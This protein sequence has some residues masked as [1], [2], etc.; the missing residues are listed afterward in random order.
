MDN[1]IYLSI[2]IEK[3]QTH[4]KAWNEGPNPLHMPL[5]IKMMKVIWSIVVKSCGHSFADSVYRDALLAML[6]LFMSIWK[7]LK[8]FSGRNIIFLMDFMMVSVWIL[9]PPSMFK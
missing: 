8:N 7:R 3:N 6:V 1:Y 5:T 2:S 4:L 9:N